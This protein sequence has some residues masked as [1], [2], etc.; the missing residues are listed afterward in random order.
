MIPHPLSPL[1]QRLHFHHSDAPLCA[2]DIGKLKGLRH[3]TVIDSTAGSTS[4]ALWQEEHLPGFHVPLHLHD[5]EEIITV[6]TGE[7]E[8]ALEEQRFLIGPGQS[9]LLPAWRAHGFTVTSSVPVGLL[10]I[11]GSKL[12]GIFKVDGTPS[13][14]PWDGGTGHQFD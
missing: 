6:I 10:A 7:I 11:F 14:P 13:L 1:P 12:P 5:C 2:L 4:L 8:A 9:I 3:R